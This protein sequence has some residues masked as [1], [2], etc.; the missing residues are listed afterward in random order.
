MF[1]LFFFFFFFFE[2][3]YF[4]ENFSYL[5]NFNIKKKTSHNFFFW[6][7]Y[8]SRKLY[9]KNF[10]IKKKN[11]IVFPQVIQSEQ[12][13]STCSSVTKGKVVTSIS[14]R[15][16]EDTISELEEL[17]EQNSKRLDEL[18]KKTTEHKEALKEL[19]RLKMDVSHGFLYF[20]IIYFL[21]FHFFYYFFFLYYT[22]TD[23]M[24][25]EISQNKAKYF[26]VL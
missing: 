11:L 14:N 4:Q 20:I 18:E 13:E 1:S 9:L 17:R 5:K 10:N 12:G 2:G 26:N 19:E 21:F 22:W 3:L 16:M 6:G 15:K 25:L 8:F 24:P 7:T 23:F